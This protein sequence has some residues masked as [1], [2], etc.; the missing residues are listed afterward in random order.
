MI[1]FVAQ[2]TAR[3]NQQPSSSAMDPDVSLISRSGDTPRAPPH[4]YE[5]YSVH[6][7]LFR[8]PATGFEAQTGSRFATTAAAL[9]VVLALDDDD[10]L[11]IDLDQLS[12]R[13][14]GRITPI[15]A[16]S[17][18]Y[19]SVFVMTVDIIRELLN[20]WDE[21]LNGAQAVVLIDELETHLHPRWK[22]QVMTSLRKVLPR[23]QFIVTTHDPLC[24][25]GMDDGEV[26]VLQRDENDHIH[27]LAESVQRQ[28]NDCG[29]T[30]NFRL[31]RLGEHNRPLN[32]DR[33]RPDSPVILPGAQ[34]PEQPNL[35]PPLR[36]WISSTVW[37]SATARA[38]KSSK[39]PSSSILRG[40]KQGMAT[41]ALNYVLLPLMQSLR[42]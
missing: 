9:R 38:S 40:G 15:D 27:R 18:G 30:I 42:H 5:L 23:V 29:T 4:G 22:M 33:I 32:R 3:T 26:V 20:Y 21:I 8:I 34:P 31:F 25:R 17:E 14:N 12:V 7:P 10:E 1:Q 13:A 16:L 39:M 41:P 28:R 37:S 24:L 35:L 11:L 19:R 2:S 36:P 6:L